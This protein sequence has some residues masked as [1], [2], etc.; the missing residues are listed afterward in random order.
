MRGFTF[1][2]DEL[3]LSDAAKKKIKRTMGIIERRIEKLIE[4]YRSGTL[5]RLPG[6]TLNESFEIYVMNEL[7][8]ARDK[9]G[10]VADE[11][12]ELGNSGIIMTRTGARGSNL[13]IGQM[14]ASVGQQAVR[15]KRIM[16]GYVNRALSHFKAGDPTPKAL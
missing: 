7:A 10:K 11:D 13:N 2:Y 12:F 5:P 14:A 15:G 8:E 4:S 9:A 6:Q 3:E 1:S 16:R